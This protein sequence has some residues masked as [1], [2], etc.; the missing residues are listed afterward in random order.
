MRIEAVRCTACGCRTKRLERHHY[1]PR[2]VF[3]DLA[4]TFPV[5]LLCGECHAEYHDE[6]RRLAKASLGWLAWRDL[7]ETDDRCERC[8]VMGSDPSG[9]T[10]M[11]PYAFWN[12]G[13]RWHRGGL[14][15]RCFDYF[16]GEMRRHLKRANK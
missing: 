8:F 5:K 15:W 14:C 10:R 6:E 9:E 2:V 7:V 4:D 11:M 12:H 1:A 13:T 16:A 3:G